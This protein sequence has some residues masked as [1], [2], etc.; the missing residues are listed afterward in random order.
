MKL[1]I[2]YIFVKRVLDIIMSALLSIILFPIFIISAIILIFNLKENP[3]FMQKRPGH[4]EK[5]FTLLKLKTLRSNNRKKSLSDNQ[6]ITRVST[7]IRKLRI[8][9]IPQLI[10]IFR[11]EMSFI[12]PRPLL[13]EYL[14]LYSPKQRLRHNVLPGITGLAQVNGSERLEFD[15]RIDLDLKYIKN[16]SFKMDIVIAFKTFY[17]VITDFYNVIDHNLLPKFK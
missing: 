7:I 15:K 10:N 16:L 14:P 5:I 13:M 11:G 6:R 4:K 3:I 2:K 12:G 9:E 8:D 1:T 17:Y